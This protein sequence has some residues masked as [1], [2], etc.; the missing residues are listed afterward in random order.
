MSSRLQ[1]ELD[2]H[3]LNNRQTRLEQLAAQKAELQKELKDIAK[4]LV[5]KNEDKVYWNNI[6]KQALDATVQIRNESI[7]DDEGHVFTEGDHTAQNR[8]VDSMRVMH[9]ELRITTEEL[10]VL[11]AE[12]VSKLIEQSTGKNKDANSYKTLLH[13]DNNR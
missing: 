3:D 5:F 12:L 6:R 2:L 9:R 7:S 8:R 13:A 1:M 11:R 4:S 10:R